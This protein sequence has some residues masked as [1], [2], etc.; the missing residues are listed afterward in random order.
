[1]EMTF[2]GSQS[3]PLFASSWTPSNTGSYAGTCIFLVILAIINRCLFAGKQILERKWTH[4][5]LHRKPIVVRG[6]P[7]GTTYISEREEMEPGTLIAAGGTEEH[8]KIITRQKQGPFPWR[9]STDF[10][11]ACYV[12][13]L[14][15]TTYLL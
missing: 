2:F 10:P 8:V 3:T 12:T 15:A 7:T 14:A 5:E 11:R 6:K 13:V 1:M 4:R 9:W